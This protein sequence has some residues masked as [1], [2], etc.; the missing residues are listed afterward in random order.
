MSQGTERPNTG[1]SV[2]RDGLAAVAMILLTVALIAFVIS[3]LL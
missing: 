2:S 3:S 1:Q